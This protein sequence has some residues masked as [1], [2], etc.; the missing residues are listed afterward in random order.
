MPANEGAGECRAF[1]VVAAASGR[2]GEVLAD[3][4]VAG[5]SVDRAARRGGGVA[6]E[7]EMFAASR[8]LR[9]GGMELGLGPFGLS[10]IVVMLD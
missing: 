1:V 8:G 4:G 10:L 2:R 6:L 7:L 9:G 5:E 3:D